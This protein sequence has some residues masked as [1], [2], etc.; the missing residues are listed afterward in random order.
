MKRSRIEESV[1]R[2]LRT[3]QRLRV[4]GARVSRA[5][6]GGRAMRKFLLST[7]LLAIA[8][9][10]GNAS[11]G[12][13]KPGADGGTSGDD[14]GGDD[15]SPA[16]GKPLARGLK[17]SVGVF[18]ATKAFIVKDGAFQASPNAPV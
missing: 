14:G 1:E 7:L 13:W 16:E 2:F 11:E 6:D 8:A 12:T 5:R 17:V 4:C 3:R 15:A 10:G 9:C 18:Q